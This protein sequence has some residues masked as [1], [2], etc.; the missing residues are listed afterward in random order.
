[1]QHIT[2]TYKKLAVQWLRS[3]L[4]LGMLSVYFNINDDGHNAVKSGYKRKTKKKLILL[5]QKL[6]G[7]Y[8]CKMI[9]LGSQTVAAAELVSKVSRFA[10]LSKCQT[11]GATFLV[12]MVNWFGVHN[13]EF[14]STVSGFGFQVSRI[15]FHDGQFYYQ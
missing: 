2:A 14:I 13:I 6:F 9:G 1:L 12:S 10:S 7:K 8:Y 3:G 5:L 11:V 4:E 15:G